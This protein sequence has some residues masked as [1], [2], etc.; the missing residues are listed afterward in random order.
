[1]TN[2]PIPNLTIENSTGQ[3]FVAYKKG[4]EAQTLTF[5][6]T[7][8]VED[9]DGDGI[10]DKVAVSGTNLLFYKGQTA[11]GS[12]ALFSTNAVVL[13]SS[14]HPLYLE[15]SRATVDSALEDTVN[16][17]VVKPDSVTLYF[18]EFGFGD[19][20][21]KSVN[22]EDKSPNPQMEIKVTRHALAFTSPAKP[23]CPK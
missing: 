15:K 22:P 18:S 2:T 10:K 8:V 4:E 21:P 16:H 11:P 13:F 17:C 6:G 3:Y 5:H 12:T 14:K 9:F 20:M 7:E 23:L 1:M 19:E